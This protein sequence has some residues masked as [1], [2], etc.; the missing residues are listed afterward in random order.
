MGFRDLLESIQDRLDEWRYER[1]SASMLGRGRVPVFSTASQRRRF[2]L[3]IAALALLAVGIV[4]EWLAVRSGSWTAVIV[5]VLGALLAAGAY[6]GGIEG[7]GGRYRW[8]IRSA[9]ALAFALV[10]GAL[11]WQLTR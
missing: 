9:V 2:Y 8:R 3:G 11:W 7:W 4:M 5:V 10:A 6:L 1:E